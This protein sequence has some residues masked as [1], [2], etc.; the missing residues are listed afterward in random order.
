MSPMSWDADPA[1]SAAQR[2]SEVCDIIRHARADGMNPT[3]QQVMRNYRWWNR[4]H[5]GLLAKGYLIRETG[6]GGKHNAR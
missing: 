6:F 5:R 2:K 1:D 4:W 3:M